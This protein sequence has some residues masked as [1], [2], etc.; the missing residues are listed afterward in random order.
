MANYPGPEFNSRVDRARLRDAA[1]DRCDTQEGVLF[2]TSS[3]LMHALDP[4]AGF[5][6]RQSRLKHACADGT[7]HAAWHRV[8]S[9]E[10]S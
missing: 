1:F 5:S 3:P 7:F 8:T 2:R 4:D 9:S 10:S 6:A